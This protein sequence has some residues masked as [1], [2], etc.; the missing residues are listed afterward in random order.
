MP[1]TS[2]EALAQ[3]HLSSIKGAQI[4]NRTLNVPFSE[5]ILKKIKQEIGETENT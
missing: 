3:I 4:Y 5:T 1:I 2:A